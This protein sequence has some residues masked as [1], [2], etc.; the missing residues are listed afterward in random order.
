[1]GFSEKMT[2]KLQIKL[3]QKKKLNKNTFLS[4][5]I[6]FLY[7]KFVNKKYFPFLKLFVQ[8]KLLN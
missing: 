7:N 1:M 6:S 5:S 8:F 3:V 4:Y 2:K